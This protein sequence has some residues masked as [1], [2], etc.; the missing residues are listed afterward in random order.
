MNILDI[1]YDY[2]I[3]Q[4]GNNK[5]LCRCPSHED[6]SPSL[7]ITELSDKILVHCFAGCDAESIMAAIG[8]TVNDLFSDDGT[9]YKKEKA[10]QFRKEQF[11]SDY[12]LI[13]LGESDI[14][15][16]KEFSTHDKQIFK[17]AILR[18]NKYE[19]DAHKV[20]NNLT[21]Q[22]RIKT[23]LETAYYEWNLKK[24]KYND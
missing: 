14:K 18:V 10:V 13:Q 9:E 21:I 1:F 5:Y 12:R 6:K 11:M 3:K 22:H 24:D 7:A 20:Y 4:T 19:F 17:E 8:L 2:G 16:G 23:K 15:Q